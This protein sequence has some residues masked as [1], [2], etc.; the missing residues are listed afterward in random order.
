MENKFKWFSVE[1]IKRNKNTKADELA[2]VVA[3]KTTLSPCVFF[4]TIEDSSI[5]TTE[6]E[7]TMVYLHHHYELDNITELLKM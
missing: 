3:R 2:K 7:P 5:K 4:Q 1:H 6:L